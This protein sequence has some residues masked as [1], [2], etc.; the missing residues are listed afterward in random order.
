VMSDTSSENFGTDW[1][2][3][4]IA[5]VVADYFEMLRLEL[6]GQQYNK[7]EHRRSLQQLISRTD[8]SIEKK[9]QN[10]SAVLEILEL[11]RIN[12]YQPLAKFQQ[13]LLDEIEKYLLQHGVPK[14]EIPKMRGLEEMTSLFIELPPSITPK[15]VFAKADVSKLMRKFDPAARDAKNRELGMLGEERALENEISILWNR[16]RRDLAKKVRHVSKEVGDGLGYDIHSF[17][18]NGDDRLVEV[19]TTTGSMTTP[20]FITENERLVSIERQRHYKLLRLYD[21][22]RSPKVFELS[23]PLENFVNLRATVYQASFN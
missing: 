4:E 18:V 14:F 12:G 17:E 6:A 20:F 11:P 19:K 16:G 3:E 23:P 21:F 8:G 2:A 10:I 15:Q 22:A 9:R 7:S 13:A 1:N 5:L